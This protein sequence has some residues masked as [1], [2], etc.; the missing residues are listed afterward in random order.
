MTLVTSGLTGIPSSASAALEQ[1]LVSR[2]MTRL[3]SAGSTLFAEKWKRRATPLRRRYW[4]H[5]AR[6]RPTSGSAC[7]SVPTPQTHDV[8]TRGNTEADCHYYPHDLSNAAILASVPSPCTPNGGRSCSTDV[9]DAT[10]KTID[11]RKH[12]ASLEHAVKFALASCAT[13]N[14]TNADK[15]VRTAEGAENEAIRKSWNNDLC[16]MALASVSTPQA[17]SPNSLRGRGQD[18]M[19]RK[20]GGHAVNLQDPVTLYAP[21]V[22]PDGSIRSRLDQLPRKAQLADSGPIA[23]G[24]TGAT[25]STGQ[26]D[27]AYSR[28]LQGLPPEWCDCAAMAIR[29]LRLLR[30][31]SSKRQSRR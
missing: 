31:N 1:S 16:T 9:M 30:R 20:E 28:W 14:A 19:K 4:E 12:T 18:P 15:S 3:D 5:T 27:P 6:V 2:L 17:C 26:L 22:D 11:G 24:G 8:T 29:S 23:T 10:G 7:T 13:P 25:A 21:G